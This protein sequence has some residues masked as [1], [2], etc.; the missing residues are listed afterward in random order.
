MVFGVPLKVMDILTI[1]S[2]AFSII[3]EKGSE[4]IEILLT[5]T[6]VYR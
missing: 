3:Q 6:D 4:S 2:K 5:P 1:N